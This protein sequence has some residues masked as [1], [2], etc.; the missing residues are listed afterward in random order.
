[1][2]EFQENRESEYNEL[3]FKMKRIHTLQGKIHSYWENPKSKWMN[4]FCDNDK[5][6]NLTYGFILIFRNLE[7]LY[8]EVQ[9]KCS[10]EER[11][12]VEKIIEEIDKLILHEEECIMEKKQRYDNMVLLYSDEK[13]SQL[14]TKLRKLQYRLG[15]LLQ[16]HGYNPDKGEDEGL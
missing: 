7:N 2:V 1:M 16:N 9:P 5:Q 14:K 3:A 13:W 15:E 8:Y 12:E 6:E 11:K 10:E 4:A